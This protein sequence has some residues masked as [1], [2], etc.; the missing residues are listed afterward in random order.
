MAEQT[1]ESVLT[2]GGAPIRVLQQGPALLAK[3]RSG[4]HLGCLIGLLAASAS[5]A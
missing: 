4:G 1:R 5:S 3:V 2:V